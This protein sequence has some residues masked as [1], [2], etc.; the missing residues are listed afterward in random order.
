MTALA[1]ISTVIVP[2]LPFMLPGFALASPPRTLA[3]LPAAI[4]RT[5][6]WSIVLLTLGSLLAISL[7]LPIA[8]AAI[9]AVAFAVITARWH[10]LRQRATLW[11]IFIGTI[12]ALTLFVIFAAPYL[13][14]HDGLPTGDSQKTIF[15]ADKIISHPALPDYAQSE[16]LLNRD[17]VDFYTPGL[18]ALTALVMQFSGHS[19]M[20]VGLFSIAAAIATAAIGFSLAALVLPKQA[21]WLPLLLT[22]LLILTNLRY[23]RYLREPGYHFQNI[24]GELLLFGLL[25]LALGLIQ[26]WRWRDAVLALAATAT[27]AL[28][29]QFSAFLAVFI[30]LPPMVMLLHRYRRELIQATARPLLLVLII[31]SLAAIAFSG[32]ALGLHHKVPHLFTASPHLLPLTPAPLDY[33]RLMGLPWLLAGLGGLVL[34]TRYALRRRLAD[35]A[36]LGFV[37]SIFMLLLLSQGPRL[38]LD[39]PPVRTLFYTVIPLSITGAYLISVISR[40]INKAPPA[41]PRRALYA[42][43]VL[44]VVLSAAA[45]LNQAYTLSHTVRTNAT[46]TGEELA[47]IDRLENSPA[48][49]VLIDDYNRR[50]ASWLLL[51]S[52]PMFTRIAADLERQ[53]NEAGQSPQRYRLYLKQLDFEKIFS[54]G[55]KPE[56]VQLLDRYNIHYLTGI[57][58]SSQSALQHNPSLAEAA[59]AD[60]IT[61]YTRSQQPAGD[62]AGLPASLAGWLLR[63]STLVNDIGDREDTYEHLPASLRSTR[64]SPPQADGS[65]TFRTTTAPLIPLKFNVGD[66]VRLL[67][68]KEHTGRPDVAVELL[69]L[70]AAPE[71]NVLTIV[72]PSGDVYELSLSNQPLKIPAHQVLWDKEG[73]ITVTIQNPQARPVEIDFIA[74]GLARTP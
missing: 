51:A 66:Y 40:H 58:G 65:R 52:Q 64:L 60:D 7:H 3:Q 48:G 19:L 73:F 14:I 17:P 45:S 5:A 61:L 21:G 49:G 70:A 67:W 11:L 1:V 47:L 16:T 10:S 13:L 6:L 38:D 39:I 25:Y 46:L 50:S 26:R 24:F 20:A 62:A 15:W 32:F 2:L 41:L 71:N 37:L 57:N 30:L 22:P 35:T 56:L 9:T 69:V 59:A 63:P 44:L 68:D 31:A 33:P 4:S 34:L 12:P 55:S 53:M 43:L 8:L 54:L 27:L 42:L 18:H 28:T 74:L 23:L 72:A 29:H 36:P